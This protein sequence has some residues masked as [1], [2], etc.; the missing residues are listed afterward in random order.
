MKTESQLK[1]ELKELEARIL[2]ITHDPLAETDD[3]RFLVWSK[4]KPL[5]EKVTK[6]MKTRQKYLDALFECHCTNTEISRLERIN[7]QLRKMTD[8]TFKRTASL[9]RALLTMP[10][11]SLDD[12]FEIDGVLIPEFDMQFSVLHLEDDEYYGSDFIRMAA[13]LRKTEKFYDEMVFAS[14]IIE[15]LDGY[16]PSMTDEEL[17]CGNNLD[18]G[19][20][21]HGGALR[22]PKLKHI[23]V[24][25]ALYSL[26]TYMHYSV[27]DVL[28]VNDY[29]IE[30]TL[31][32]QQFSDQEGNRL[33]R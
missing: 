7:N 13:I 3:I 10:K 1:T 22:N 6:M 31:K 14:P 28:R 27:P 25:H 20:N 15:D 29:K 33:W 5:V 17:D 18:N 21:W 24:Y 19:M 26:F 32:V 30:I 4:N 8:R 2:E 16:T 23:T 9:F 12:D 11:D